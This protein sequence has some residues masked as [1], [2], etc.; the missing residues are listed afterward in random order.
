MINQ[1]FK[2]PIWLGLIGL[3]ALSGFP[4]VVFS[5]PP[6]SP[7]HLVTPGSLETDDIIVSK[8]I[9][10]QPYRRALLVKVDQDPGELVHY[11]RH[12]MQQLGFFAN[13]YDEASFR[14]VLEFHFPGQGRQFQADSAGIRMASGLYGPFLAARLD[15]E[16]RN[17]L[18]QTAR[19]SAYDPASGELVF[20][21]EHQVAN[22]NDLETALFNPLLNAFQDWLQSNAAT[23]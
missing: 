2:A 11:F 4:A 1:G 16:N 21:A 5:E 10:T 14:N 9:N 12:G 17:Y 3:I 8:D 7:Q 13:V 6:V 15:W 19:L 20:Q 18:R 23:P 22:W